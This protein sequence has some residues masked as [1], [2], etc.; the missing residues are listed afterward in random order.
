M[1]LS[2]RFCTDCGADPLV[3]AGP[4]GSAVGNGIDIRPDARRLTRASAIIEAV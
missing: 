3:R 1:S 4:P 2:L